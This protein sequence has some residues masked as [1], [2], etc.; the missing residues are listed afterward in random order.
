MDETGYAGWDE[1]GWSLDTLSKGKKDA[2]GDKG[3][4]EGKAKFSKALNI[5]K[6]VLMF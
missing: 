2:V 1:C 6:I 5:R 3:V 4:K